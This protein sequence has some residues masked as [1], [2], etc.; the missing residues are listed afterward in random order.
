MD[1]VDQLDPVH[2]EITTTIH[3]RYDTQLYSYRLTIA[4]CWTTFTF[5][6]RTTRLTYTRKVSLLSFVISN[7]YLLVQ[8]DLC[9]L[10][11]HFG[12]VHQ[13]HLET[14]DLF[15]YN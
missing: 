2:P 3:I 15:I 1:R 12:P 11:F 4:S 5:A 9:V 7:D 6:T 10:C 8:R 13:D 14:I